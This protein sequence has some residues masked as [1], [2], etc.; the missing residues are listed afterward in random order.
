MKVYPTLE[1]YAEKEKFKSSPVCDKVLK[2]AKHFRMVSA[3]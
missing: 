2:R 1:K 3:F